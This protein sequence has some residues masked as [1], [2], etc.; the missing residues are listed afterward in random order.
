MKFK[1]ST[2]ENNTF[3]NESFLWDFLENKIL[4]TF[5][6]VAHNGIRNMFNKNLFEINIIVNK[7]QNNSKIIYDFGCGTGINLMIL[8]SVFGF[9]CFGI[10][11]G[12][13]FSETH[14]RQVGNLNQ[15]ESRLKSFGVTF[16]KLD[17]TAKVDLD[18]KAD[19]VTSFD[20]I[21]H[22]PFSP[23]L[24]LKN[25]F[26]ALKSDG[27]MVVGTPNQTHFYNRLKI[28]FDKNI[29]EDFDYWYE[30]D[31]FYGHVRELTSSELIKIP[32]L[33]KLKNIK[34]FSSSYPLIYRLKSRI[35]FEF[36]NKIF[37][38]FNLNYY[39]VVISN[40]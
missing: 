38:L 13:E 20:V 23:K 19:V 9:K 4:P 22:F 30:S 10:D 36:F 37:S 16:L 21:E 5:N 15:L 14:N 24:Y 29:W 27:F 39:N 28:L 3:V 32:T 40:K 7:C 25:M 12:E 17:P 8:S 34:L 31:S 2:P 26:N 35:L 18:V 6:E 11:R 33:M 1:L